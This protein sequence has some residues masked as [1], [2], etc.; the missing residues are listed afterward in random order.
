MAPPERVIVV[1]PSKW[2]LRHQEIAA[3]IGCSLKYKPNHRAWQMWLPT[4]NKVYV[5]RALSSSMHSGEIFVATW[6]Y[7]GWASRQA[8]GCQFLAGHR[9][10]HHYHISLSVSHDELPKE[11][12][13]VLAGAQGHDWCVAMCVQ[14][15]HEDMVYYTWCTPITCMYLHSFSGNEMNGPCCDV[16]FKTPM[17][18]LY[19]LLGIEANLNRLFNRCCR[20][21]QKILWVYDL[22]RHF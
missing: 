3:Y 6:Y 8:V 11:I 16:E 19:L 4:S 12:N 1:F 13:V 18:M 5:I 20:V 2:H 7:S 15:L 21:Q 9:K 14:Y 10:E 17:V 22:N